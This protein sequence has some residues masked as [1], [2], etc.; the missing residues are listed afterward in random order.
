MD[1]MQYFEWVSTSVPFK[2]TPLVAKLAQAIQKLAQGLSAK[3][4]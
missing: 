2:L 3:K 4:I 1:G